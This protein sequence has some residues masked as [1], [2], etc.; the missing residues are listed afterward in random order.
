MDEEKERQKETPKESLSDPTGQVKE[1]LESEG[2]DPDEFDEDE[3][4][5]LADLL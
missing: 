1:K 3:Q 5:E 2:L 4:E